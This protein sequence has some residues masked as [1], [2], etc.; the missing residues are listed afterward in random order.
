[1]KQLTIG[2][3]DAGQRLDR[4]LAKTFPDLPASLCYKSI[5]LKRIKVNRK[6]AQGNQRLEAGDTVELFLADAF[7]NAPTDK[8][9]FLSAQGRV[10]IVYEDENLLLLDKP[11]GLLCHEDAQE[12]R[13]TLI[14]RVL[15]Y[16]YDTG[17]YIP[18][19]EQ[20]FT[21]SLCNRIDRNTQGIVAAAKNAAALREMS[22][23][24][25]ERR[26][27]KYYL[28]VVHGKPDKPHAVLRGYHT[29]DG[30][31]NRVTIT[32]AM[33]PGAKTAVTEYWLLYEKDGLSL[34][35]VQLHTGRTHQIRAHLAAVGCPLMGDTKYGDWHPRPGAKYQALCSYGVRFPTLPDT[36][37]LSRLSDKAFCLEGIEFITKYFPQIQKT[38]LQNKQWMVH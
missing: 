15:R 35:G 14:N 37:V 31:Q 10:R 33:R 28:C 2:N 3:N 21:P 27:E 9:L 1:M 4:F 36:S 18:A 13:D 8:P 34:L 5:R 16:L 26:M 20:S 30:Q 19:Q 32:P 6:R 23:L 29:K 22:A 7:L 25:R 38:D 11:P 17:Q 24:I 12:Q